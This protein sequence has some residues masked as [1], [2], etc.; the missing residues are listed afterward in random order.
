MPVREIKLGTMRHECPDC[1][2]LLWHR[3][4]SNKQYG[5]CCKKG[6]VKLEMPEPPPSDLL[7]LLDHKGPHHSHFM[8]FI[9]AYNCS[10]QM[11]SSGIDVQEHV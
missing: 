9:R 8:R 2:A 3:E 11:A 7:Q 4:L 1:H 10:L 6:K 5:L